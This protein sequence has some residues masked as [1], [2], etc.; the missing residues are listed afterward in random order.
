M[1]PSALAPAVRGTVTPVKQTAAAPVAKESPGNWRHPRLAEITQRQSKTV[2]S[3]K[4]AKQVAYNVAAL[5]IFIF[6]RGVVR[7]QLPET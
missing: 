2:F 3:E 6:L 7:S 5:A 4:N 1:P